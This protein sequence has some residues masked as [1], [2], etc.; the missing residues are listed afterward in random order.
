MALYLTFLSLELASCLFPFL[1]W[2]AP[3]SLN[4][5]CYLKA[6]NPLPTQSNSNLASYK[7]LVGVSNC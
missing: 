2:L 3:Y 5:E 7:A 6:I 4:R 1:F